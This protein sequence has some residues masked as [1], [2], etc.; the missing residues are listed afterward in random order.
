VLTKLKR[1][2][3]PLQST[4]SWSV[5]SVGNA[6]NLCGIAVPPSAVHL[7]GFVNKQSMR[8][9]VPENPY[10]VAETSFYPADC[11]VW[12]A[13]DKHVFTGPFFVERRRA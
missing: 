13:I 9:W 8:F 10:R 5:S 12:C 1:R 6:Y 11:T 2:M 7:D 4:S 3:W